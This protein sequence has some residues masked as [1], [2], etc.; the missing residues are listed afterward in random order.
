[1]AF[2]PFMQFMRGIQGKVGGNKFAGLQGNNS[3]HIAFLRQLQRE[4]YMNDVMIAPLDKM[5]AVVFDIETTGFFPEKGDRII[6]IGAIKLEKGEIIENQAFYSLINYDGELSAEVSELTGIQ[7]QQLNDAP[8]LSDVLVRFFKF[9]EDY[10]LIAHHANHEKIF[11][12]Q[13]CWSMFRTPFRHRLFDTSFLYRLIEPEVMSFRLE[14]LCEK[15]GIAVEHRHHA[16]EDA[17]LTARLWL[18]YIEAVRVIGCHTMNDVY[19][20]IANTR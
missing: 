16:L 15:H 13:A 5:N 10:P 9:V 11:M 19:E 3:Q 6:S 8:P 20:K 18:Y 7:Q 1:M 2:E 14:D 17:K 4:S 12:Q